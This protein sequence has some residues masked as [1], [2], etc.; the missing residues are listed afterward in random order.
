MS[1]LTRCDI[2]TRINLDQNSPRIK[3]RQPNFELLAEG[4]KMPLVKTDNGIDSMQEVNHVISEQFKGYW[5]FID[6]APEIPKVIGFKNGV[7]RTDLDES[8]RQRVIR[9]RGI[10][11]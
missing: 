5:F 3:E 10:V 1:K 6:T 4:E 7:H 2:E 9:S 11:V 8:T